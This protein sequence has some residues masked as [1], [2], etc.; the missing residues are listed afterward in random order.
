MSGRP[1]PADVAAAALRDLAAQ[2][3]EERG[4]PADDVHGGLLAMATGLIAERRGG[5]FADHA[6]RLVGRQMRR[7]PR[8]VEGETS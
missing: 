2:L 8:P 5:V 7:V 6:A 1:D 3:I 4:L